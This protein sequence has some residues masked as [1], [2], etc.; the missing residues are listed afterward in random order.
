MKAKIKRQK[1][2]TYND[3]KY[4]SSPEVELAK[5]LDSE[6]YTDLISYHKTKYKYVV[7]ESE[8]VYTP[9]WYKNNIVWE[10]KGI[11]KF[12]LTLEERKKYLYIKSQH[13]DID[14]RFIFTHPHFPINKNS[15]TTYAMWADKNGFKWCERIPPKQWINDLYEK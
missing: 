2:L 8:H 6:G 3:I 14:L 1:A 10:V 4:D 11:Y 5:W 7:P 15:K 12:G 9:D 13:P